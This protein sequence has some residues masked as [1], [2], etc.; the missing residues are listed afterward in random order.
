MGFRVILPSSR[1]FLPKFT[2]RN[3]VALQGEPV[4]L[5]LITSVLEAAGRADCYMCLIPPILVNMII[6]RKVLTVSHHGVTG[7][8][9]TEMPHLHNP[10]SGH[11]MH[12]N[13]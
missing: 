12:I 7:I 9:Y 8:L 13:A 2:V 6:L 10:G 5:A 11:R 1:D 3:R 4:F